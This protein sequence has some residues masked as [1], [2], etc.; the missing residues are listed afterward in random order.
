LLGLWHGI[1]AGWQIDS[2]DEGSPSRPRPA[3]GDLATPLVR[4]HEVPREVW[5]RTVILWDKPDWVP[6]VESPLMEWWEDKRAGREERRDLW[7]AI[8][9]VF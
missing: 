5:A 6:E 4:L 1:D 3:S 7:T 8:T 2:R 9:L